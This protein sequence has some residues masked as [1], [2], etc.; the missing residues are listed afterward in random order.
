MISASNCQT[1]YKKLTRI[2]K[3]P[4]VS[5]LFRPDFVPHTGSTDSQDREPHCYCI[6][7]IKERNE[8]NLLITFHLPVTHYWPLGSKCHQASENI[9][10]CVCVQ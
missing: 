7:R 1:P 9:S 10:L 3:G 4:S 6:G 2:V 8:L 5:L